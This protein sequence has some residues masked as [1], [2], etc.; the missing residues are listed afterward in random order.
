L[1]EEPDDFVEVPPEPLPEGIYGMAIATLIRDTAHL[2]DPT[3]G[4]C[5]SC[6]KGGRLSMSMIL[7]G[8]SLA[9]Q[10]FLVVCTK[11]LITPPGVKAIRTLY[12][13]YERT[14]YDGHVIMSKNNYSRGIDGFFN[15]SN[16]DKLPQEDQDLACRIPLSQPLFLFVIL[17]IWTMTVFKHMRNTVNLLLR[18]LC[19][20]TVGSCSEAVEEADGVHTIVGLTCCQKIGATLINGAVLCMNGFL[21]WLGGRWLVSTTG[22]S[23]LLLNAIALE[24][25]LDLPELVYSVMVPKRTQIETQNTLIPHLYKQESAGICSLFGMYL[26]GVLGVFLVLMYMYHLQMV[27]PDYKFDVA[28]V[29]VT[30]LAK[31]MTLHR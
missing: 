24:F 23:D 6:I 2:S 14:M 18:M 3:K 22:F 7:I 16:F 9:L 4:K 13:E 30:Y 15:A 28:G 12:G 26:L 21:L 11:T 25:I 29:C 31:E 5:S 17:M 19:V 1:E 10:L 20:P 27:L 8:I